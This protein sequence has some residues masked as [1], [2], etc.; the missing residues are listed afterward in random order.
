MVRFICHLWRRKNFICSFL[1]HI[2]NPPLDLLHTICQFSK[3]TLLSAF[4]EVD[5]F[6]PGGTS[7][8]PLSNL[9]LT[10]PSVMNITYLIPTLPLFTYMTSAT[11]TLTVHST[12]VCLAA[13]RAG[14]GLGGGTVCPRRMRRLRAGRGGTCIG[15]SFKVRFES[16]ILRTLL[17]LVSSATSSPFSIGER[18]WPHRERGERNIARSTFVWLMADSGARPWMAVREDTAE[19][20]VCSGLA[21]RFCKQ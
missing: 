21:L 20:D 3:N 17:S 12:R 2:A 6:G 15:T 18:S 16:F 19:G 5:F 13:V 1:S 11:W 8:C 7:S 14:R 9:V 10:S 4:R